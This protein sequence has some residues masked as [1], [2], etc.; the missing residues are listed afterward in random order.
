[1]SG[2]EQQYAKDI[3]TWDKQWNLICEELKKH[4]EITPKF[5]DILLETK[6]SFGKVVQQA[7]F[8]NLNM[9]TVS[10]EDIRQ[11]WRYVNE[12]CAE[13]ITANRF[14]PLP[15][16]ASTNR[17]NDTDRLYSYFSISYKDSAYTDI[18]ATGVREI[19]AAENDDVW[20]CRFA[21]SADISELKF[22][23]FS[24]VCRI[25]KDEGEYGNFLV[26]KLGKR[27]P[28]DKNKLTYW[29][30]QTLLQIFHESDMFSPIDKSE[31]QEEQRLKYKPFHVICDYL[32]RQGY[33]G[34]I[35][36]SSVFKR[37]RCLALFN[38]DY[39][40]CEFDTLEKI[41][42]AKALKIK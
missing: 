2:I 12:S 30:I 32:E 21:F 8:E 38:P 18:E 15:E 35:Y 1:M 11:L 29:L 20:K 41:N 28:V 26:S 5:E 40:V 25:P 42:V 33:N 4:K 10:P 7:I 13:K 31:N 39:A 23:D 34:I 22:I 19:R 16:Y 6:S 24:P 37:G 14:I 27:L 9:I 17:M 3:S 36:R